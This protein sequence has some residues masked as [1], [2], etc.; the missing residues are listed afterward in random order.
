LPQYCGCLPPAAANCGT[1]AALRHLFPFFERQ[2][3]VDQKS[4]KE[5]EKGFFLLQCECYPIPE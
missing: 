1:R 2:P 4:K 3:K 5:V